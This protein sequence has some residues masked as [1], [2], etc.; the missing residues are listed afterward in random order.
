MNEVFFMTLD[1]L[2]ESQQDLVYGAGLSP[3]VDIQVA[4]LGI[5]PCETRWVLGDSQT[6]FEFLLTALSLP[7]IDMF[8]PKGGDLQ[9]QLF[10]KGFESQ[11]PLCYFNQDQ[12]AR[13]PG[14]ALFLVLTGWVKLAES[15]E[16]RDRFSEVAIFAQ[17]QQ[18]LLE[19]AREFYNTIDAI[20]QFIKQIPTMETDAV[21]SVCQK[22]FV[23]LDARL[24]EAACHCFLADLYYGK[25]STNGQADESV[26]SYFKLHSYNHMVR[27]RLLISQCFNEH[28]QLINKPS[29]NAQSAE[30]NIAIFLDYVN[31]MCR[32]QKND[33]A[34]SCL[35]QDSPDPLD[36]KVDELLNAL[37]RRND[38]VATSCDIDLHA[39]LF[40]LFSYEAV[41]GM[42]L[43]QLTFQRM[44]SRS[45]TSEIDG[46]PPKYDPSQGI[47]SAMSQCGL[48]R[49]V[50]DKSGS[51]SAMTN[52]TSL[53]QQ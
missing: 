21:K 26:K 9:R 8:A 22:H 28:N 45:S 36:N 1:Y 13:E 15:S 24:R 41:L 38:L 3:E 46:S 25:V 47:A 49:K 14:L 50:A 39:E 29:L 6:V 5:S 34:P 48:H 4:H 19:E 27:A 43:E 20:T 23:Q 37:S 12:L 40:E 53:T 31:E 33:T 51:A 11:N 18:P 17:E 44:R 16:F 7:S 42:S 35:K 2:T 52:S 30:K 32:K 10:L